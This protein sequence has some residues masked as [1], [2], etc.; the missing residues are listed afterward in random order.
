MPRT[1]PSLMLQA[2]RA[3]EHWPLAGQFFPTA[4]LMGGKQTGTTP[5]ADISVHLDFI[6]FPQQPLVRDVL[7]LH[8]QKA[9][10]FAWGDEYTKRVKTLLAGIEPLMNQKHLT[11]LETAYAVCQAT[12]NH[13]LS[14]W[15]D[16]RPYLAEAF[17]KEE[18]YDFWKTQFGL[19]ATDNGLS[20]DTLLDAYTGSMRRVFPKFSL[21]NKEL[22]AYRI[23]HNE[24]P[25]IHFMEQY[26]FWLSF[27]SHILLPLSLYLQLLEPV[28]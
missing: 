8:A 23:K 9:L 5:H 17:T 24:T 21:T 16:S 11:P 7:S 20:T 28:C 10:L 19:M 14:Q 2:I 3:A 22:G 13:T 15:Y 12:M 18:W 26:E 25:D 6:D 1:T 27:G 4:T